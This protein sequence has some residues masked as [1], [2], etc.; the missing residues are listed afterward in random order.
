MKSLSTTDLDKAMRHVVGYKGAHPC[1]MMPQD[2]KPPYS[3]IVNTD[4]SSKPG[5]HWIAIRVANGKVYFLDSFGRKFDNLSFPVDFR[6]TMR[7]MMRRRHLKFNNKLIQNL[8]SNAC[9]YYAVYF[10]DGMSMEKRPKN[11]LK[12]FTED[13]KRNDRFV[14]SYFKNIFK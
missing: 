13:L 4:N 3:L 10:L 11:L 12:V 7:K 8:T 14:V 6:R 1:D 9:G 5:D 2:L